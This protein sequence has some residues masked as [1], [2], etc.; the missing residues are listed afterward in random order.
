MERS[1][2]IYT[3][4]IYTDIYIYNLYLNVYI[5]WPIYVCVCVCAV[6]CLVAQL[7]LILCDSMDYRPPGSSV[8]GDSPGK[9]TG[10]GCHSL[11]QGIFPIQD[12][13]PGLPH[14]RQILC[15]LGHQRSPF[16]HTHTHTHT[17]THMSHCAACRILVPQLGVNCAS[18]SG[19]VES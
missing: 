15:H 18:Y 11:L 4:Y 13:N 2:K 17:H 12:L 10:V 1:T 14:C 7:S 9:N 5:V 8:H 16:I 3:V 6:L 19:N